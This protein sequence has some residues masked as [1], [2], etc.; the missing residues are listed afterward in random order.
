MNESTPIKSQISGIFIPVSDIEAGRA[1]YCQLLGQE[2]SM[3]IIAGH[4][5][6]IPLSSNGQ[7]IVLDSK[8]FSPDNV[9]RTP[10][11]HFDTDDIEQAYAYMRDKEIKLTTGIENGHWFNFQDPDGN[12]LMICKV[13]EPN[14]IAQETRSVSQ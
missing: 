7:N 11:F 13:D 14:T 3:D 5:C 9:F 1:W 4:L 10:M 8:V 2:P 6:C 12:H